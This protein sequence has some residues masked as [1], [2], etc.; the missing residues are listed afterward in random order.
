MTPKGICVWFGLVLVAGIAGTD[1]QV[2]AQSL[3]S[4]TG[5]PEAREGLDQYCV[6]CHNDRS[7]QAGLTLQNISTDH[8]GQRESDI[9]IWE[10]VV[11]KLRARTMPPAGRPR[12]SVE[13]YDSIAS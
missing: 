3:S 2:S 12:P 1:S 6:T 9:E 13:S 8:V 7:R 5:V 11:K 10:K 4:S